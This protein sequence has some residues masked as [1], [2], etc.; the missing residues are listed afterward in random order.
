MPLMLFSSGNEWSL[1]VGRKEKKKNGACLSILFLLVCCEAHVLFVW[2][3]KDSVVGSFLICYCLCLSAHS[4][5][6]FFI[7]IPFTHHISLSSSPS[8]ASTWHSSPI[9]SYKIKKNDLTRT[10]TGCDRWALGLAGPCQLRS[11]HIR[12]P[13]PIEPRHPLDPF[14]W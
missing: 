9:H 8:F 11:L 6:A 3:T 4:F 13:R 5:F 10:P 1:K 12:A 14:G 7:S 2:S